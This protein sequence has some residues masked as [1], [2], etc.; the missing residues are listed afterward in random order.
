MLRKDR[1]E[2]GREEDNPRESQGFVYYVYLVA[3]RA[4]G[5]RA[6]QHKHTAS[7]IS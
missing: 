1:K 3:L 6:G 2:G 5:G 7:K 4:G